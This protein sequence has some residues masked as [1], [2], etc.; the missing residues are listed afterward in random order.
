MKFILTSIIALFACISIN[1]Q[2]IQKETLSEEAS[3]IYIDENTM[4]YGR[5][6]L[7]VTQR[8]SPKTIKKTAK[9]NKEEPK[10]EPEI[11]ENKRTEQ[12]SKSVLFAFPFK[13]SSSYSKSSSEQVAV[14]QQ[15][16]GGQQQITKACQKS[17]YQASN[18]LNPTLYLP[19]QRQ[20]LSIAATQCGLLTSFASK[21]PPLFMIA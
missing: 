6:L 19:E 1:A 12:K 11:T 13:P 17:T 9:I 15:R 14:F 4:I 7:Y 5:E 20:K 10:P 18:N 2:D 8:P 21:F 16:K 3:C